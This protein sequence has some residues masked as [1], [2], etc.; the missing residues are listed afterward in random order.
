VNAKCYHDRT[1][2][3]VASQEGH[4]DAVRV[5]LDHGTHV[6]SQ[7]DVN[8]MPLS[9]ALNERNLKAVQI[10]LEDKTTARGT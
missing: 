3:H 9:F 4:V 1:P 2:L 7:D 8:W 5:L 10:F 6:N